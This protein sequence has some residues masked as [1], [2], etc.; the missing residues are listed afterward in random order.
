MRLLI[1]Y[2]LLVV[3]GNVIAV[4]IGFYLDKA[5]PTFAIPIALGLFFTVLGVMWP[6][7]VY[8]TERWLLQKSDEEPPKT[9]A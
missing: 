4:Q 9:D 2:V 6:L 7:A 5:A 8:V 3:V 1:V